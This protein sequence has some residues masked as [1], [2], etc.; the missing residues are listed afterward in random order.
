MECFLA[1]SSDLCSLVDGLSPCLLL[2]G[3]LITFI[4]RSHVPA[5]MAIPSLI[6]KVYLVRGEVVSLQVW[7]VASGY[8]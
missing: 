3:L 4:T 6:S 7:R 5:S 8:I 1:S 2:L